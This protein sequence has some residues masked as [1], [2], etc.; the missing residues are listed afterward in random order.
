M[1]RLLDEAGFIDVE[2]EVTRRYSLQEVAESGAS[3]AI[4]ALLCRE[5]AGIEG[6][7]ISAFIRAHKPL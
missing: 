7:F 1:G 2:V 3:A 5:R 4:A 6:K